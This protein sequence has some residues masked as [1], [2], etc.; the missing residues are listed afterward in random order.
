MWLTLASCE[1]KEWPLPVRS[2]PLQPPDV[3]SKQKSVHM[4]MPYCTLQGAIWALEGHPDPACHCHSANDQNSW[5]AQHMMVPPSSRLAGLAQVA[6]LPRLVTSGAAEFHSTSI[7]AWRRM[8]GR[9]GSCV[10]LRLS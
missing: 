9:W 8:A 4:L 10:Q 1:A 7:L 3:V 5:G 6:T 2:M